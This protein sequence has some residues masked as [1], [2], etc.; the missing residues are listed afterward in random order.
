[1]STHLTSF[2]PYKRCMCA[3]IRADAV[4]PTKNIVWELA[5]FSD[6]LREEKRGST[7]PQPKKVSPRFLRRIGDDYLRV[8][9]PSEK[10]RIGTLPTEEALALYRLKKCLGF[11]SEI[12]TSLSR[13]G[14]LARAVHKVSG[15]QRAR[16][17]YALRG[18][19]FSAFTPSFPFTRHGEAQKLTCLWHG[20]KEANG[21]RPQNSS[22]GNA[23]LIPLKRETPP[24][25]KAQPDP[26]LS[27]SPRSSPRGKTSSQP[28][29]TPVQA[30][31]GALPKRS[32]GQPQSDPEAN[33]RSPRRCLTGDTPAD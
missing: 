4:P 27:G 22:Q 31:A 29:E 10:L 8:G 17:P 11:P 6:S 14:A 16:L 21:Q 7:N 25:R 33:G 24:K 32:T 23:W 28:A 26:N 13:I 20:Q 5:H 9:N 19:W 18:G 3:G 2:S 12:C 1:M 30:D 15:A